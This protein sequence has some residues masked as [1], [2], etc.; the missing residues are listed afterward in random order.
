MTSLVR[1][2]LVV[3]VLVAATGSLAVASA[4]CS[5]E[6]TPAPA[7][8]DPRY[9]DPS[10]AVVACDGG[11]PGALGACTG[12]PKATNDVRLLPVDQSYP[13]GCRAYF[14]AQDCTPKGN[15]YCREDDGDAGT[16]RWICDR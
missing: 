1:P 7:T 2:T 14:P 4:A 8:P 3:L 12:D 15:C 16:A 5:S 6:V 11:A 9:C 10:K 13:V